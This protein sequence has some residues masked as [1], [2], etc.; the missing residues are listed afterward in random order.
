MA[1]VDALARRSASVITREPTALL[2]L[3]EPAFT[4][5]AA[6]IPALWRRIAVEIANRL[7]ERSRVIRPPNNKPVLFLG[8]STEGVKVAGEL[9]LYFRR[10]PVVTRLWTVGVF[11]VSSTAIESLVRL[12]ANADFAALVLTADDITVSRRRRHQ[13]P[14]DNVIFELGLFIGALGR[15]R[16]IIVKPQRMEVKMP[17]D[18]NGV[19]WLDYP[20]GGNTTLSTRL[21][22]IH[23]ELWRIIRMQG[24][25]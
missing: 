16:V 12:A 14:R 2:R 3:T 25:R 9:S 19:V 4:K 17:S 21:K 1:L 6:A 7:R 24:P 10:R 15:D 11:E 22:P 13:T 18:L 5:L 8:S 23:D 20:H